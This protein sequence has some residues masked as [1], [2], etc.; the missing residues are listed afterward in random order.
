MCHGLSGHLGVANLIL[1]LSANGEQHRRLRRL[2]AHAFSDRSLRLQEACL[3]GYVDL[4]IS[5]LQQR[6]ATDNGVVN[7][8]HWFNFATF[9]I[10]GDL[11]FGDSF[12]LLKDG[13]WN[14]YLSSIFGLLQYNT[15]NRLAKTLIPWPWKAYLADK[16][17]PKSRR[18]DFYYQDQL[19]REKL[20]RRIALD[21]ERQDFGIYFPELSNSLQR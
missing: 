2:L 20:S 3:Q 15:F 6:A 5:Q 10:I 21:T 7:M 4:F 11:A 13:V 8:V 12:S 17:S 9:D 16:M 18:G 1:K 14:R 19:S